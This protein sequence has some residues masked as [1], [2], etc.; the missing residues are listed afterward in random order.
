MFAVCEMVY[1]RLV[2]VYFFF[3]LIHVVLGLNACP[4]EVLFMY[5]SVVS[6]GLV[7]D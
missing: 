2:Y 7:E 3:F 5:R 1:E 6:E 4:C